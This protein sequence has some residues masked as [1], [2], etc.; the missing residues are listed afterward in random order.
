MGAMIEQY[1]V[2]C[3]FEDG[4]SVQNLF[5]SIEEKMNTCFKY[6]KSLG[7]AYNSGLDVCP[8]FIFQKK[9]TLHLKL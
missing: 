7:T 1:P 8:T 2:C 4:M 6:R 3:E 5:D 9:S